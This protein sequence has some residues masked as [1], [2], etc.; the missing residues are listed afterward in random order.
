M[1]ND[2]EP[3]KNNG[4]IERREREKPTKP[5][6]CFHYF[7]CLCQSNYQKPTDVSKWMICNLH[8]LPSVVVF[9]LLISMLWHCMNEFLS[10]ARQSFQFILILMTPLNEVN[11]IT[12]KEDTTYYFRFLIFKAFYFVS[13]KLFDFISTMLVNITQVNFLCN[14]L[15]CKSCSIGHLA[16]I[17]TF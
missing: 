6:D 5:H 11:T 13:I 4:H 17:N 2:N 16:F 3:G 7:Y 1:N 12:I 9:M 15:I 14:H 10:R 8:P